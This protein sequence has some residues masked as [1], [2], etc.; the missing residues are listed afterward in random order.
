M[1]MLE[2][3]YDFLDVYVDRSDYIHLESDTDSS[4]IALS[5][6]NMSDVIKPS[7]RKSYDHHLRGLCRDDACPVYLPRECCE[8]HKKFDRRVPGLFKTEYEGDKMIGLC[9]K[10]YVVSNRED[11]KV[12]SK[13]ISKNNV[14]DAWQIYEDVLTNQKAGSGINRG[15]RARDNTMFSYTQ[16]RSGFSYFYCKR[17]VLEDGI[18]TEPLTITLRPNA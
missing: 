16:E 17:K 15:I 5:K 13:G 9:S 6:E 14:G 18:S 7:M 3:N 4:Y 10:T 2:F 8:K 11:C 1:K 12:S